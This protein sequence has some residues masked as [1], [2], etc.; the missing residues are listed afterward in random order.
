MSIEDIRVEL[1]QAFRIVDKCSHDNRFNTEVELRIL[2]ARDSLQSALENLSLTEEEIDRQRNE[3]EKRS[4]IIDEEMMAIK[5]EELHQQID[6]LLEFLGKEK[7]PIKLSFFQC[8]T[9]EDVIRQ[10]LR[11]C[12]L[13]ETETSVLSSILKKY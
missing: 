12:D 2:E 4:N 7:H 11:K 1:T 9:I 8:K 13:F 10:C 3:D 5:E 6:D